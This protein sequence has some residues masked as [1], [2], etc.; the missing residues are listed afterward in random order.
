[1]ARRI[2]PLW[3][4]RKHLIYNAKRLRLASPPKQQGAGPEATVHFTVQR[5]RHIYIFAVRPY[6]RKVIVVVGE[7]K[8]ILYQQVTTIGKREFY[9]LMGDVLA[10]RRTEG[11]FDW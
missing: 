6:D 5:P 2:G 7:G 4:T 1:M 3:L 11:S 8:Y 9:G 10:D